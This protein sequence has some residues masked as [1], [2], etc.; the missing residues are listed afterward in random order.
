M[1]DNTRL[2]TNVGTGDLMLTFETTFSGDSCKF[3]GVGI[4]G[5]TGSPDAWTA[6]PING[7]TANGLYVDCRVIQAGTNWIGD[8]GIKGRTSGGPTSFRSI[9]ADENGVVVKASAGQLYWLHAINLHTAPLYLR[10]YNKS[11]AP[12]ASDTPVHTF[13]IPSAGTANGGGFVLQTPLG[14]PFSVGISY[15]VTTGP[16]DNN[17]GAPSANVCFLNGGYA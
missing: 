14:I 11:T 6:N 12:T 3:Q 17:T 1:A 4:C 9:D 10:L 5:V 13:V 16:L 2:G 7:S 8:V 15:R